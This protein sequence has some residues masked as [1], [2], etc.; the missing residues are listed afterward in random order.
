MDE[1]QSSTL[2]AIYA[3]AREERAWWET[4]LTARSAD[5]MTLPGTINP[6]WSFKDLVNHLNGWRRRAIDQMQADRA[7]R[8]RPADAWPAELNT[9]SDE[10]EQV[11]QINAWIQDQGSRLSLDEVIAESRSHWDELYAL[12]T[13]TSAEDMRDP[14]LFAYLDG[15]SLEEAVMTGSLWDHVHGEH[16]DDIAAWVAGKPA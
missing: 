2:E 12:I 6:E 1:T 11:D 14:Q 5:A 9:I 10:D 4:V 7:R 13:T 8:D 3:R 16:G 15:Q